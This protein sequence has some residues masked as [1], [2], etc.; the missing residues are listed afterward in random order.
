[1][2]DRAYQVTIFGWRVI[3]DSGT[4]RLSVW[5]RAGY[6]WSLRWIWRAA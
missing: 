5:R 6:V 1:M 3:W 4:R 2:S